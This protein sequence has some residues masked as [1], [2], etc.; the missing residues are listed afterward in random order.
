M[1]VSASVLHPSSSARSDSFAEATE[2]LREVVLHRALGEPVDEGLAVL[3]RGRL[4]MRA[5]TVDLAV[6]TAG[7]ADATTVLTHGW[8][9]TEL[10]AYASRRLDDVA[11]PY[12]IDVLA[13]TR[14]WR[15]TISWSADLDRLDAH[16]WWSFDGPHLSQWATRQGH[17]RIVAVRAAVDVLALLRY[18]PRADDLRHA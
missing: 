16:V 10:H 5:Q 7:R 11:L 4:A 3:L 9:P 8:R 2:A 15:G 12:L 18:L 6:D 13:A 14:R 17:L 1:T